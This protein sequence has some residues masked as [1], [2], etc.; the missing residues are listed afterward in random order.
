MCCPSAETF[1]FAFSVSNHLSLFN[2]IKLQ[3][4]FLNK[5][6]KEWS[7]TFFAGV[8]GGRKMDVLEKEMKSINDLLGNS[9]WLRS[10]DAGTNKTDFIGTR[11]LYGFTKEKADS[12]TA[13]KG[14]KG[15]RTSLPPLTPRWSRQ[16]AQEI[17]FLTQTQESRLPVGSP[18]GTQMKLQQ[19]CCQAC[20]GHEG[21]IGRIPITELTLLH[22]F[23]QQ[24]K[25]FK[26]PN[27]PQHGRLYQWGVW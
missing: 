8:K 21:I 17:E 27:P 26:S 7:S 5:P 13:G 15:V 10:P 19:R 3:I 1:K 16:A 11:N 2:K 18:S 24:Q 4:T 23:L 25:K 22:Y 6:L 12:N 14:R 20:R 9:R